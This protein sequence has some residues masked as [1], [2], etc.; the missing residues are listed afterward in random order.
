M[1]ENETEPGE[2]QVEKDE[3]LYRT[4]RTQF[5]MDKEQRL[6]RACSRTAEQRKRGYRETHLPADKTRELTEED[7]DGRDEA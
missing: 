3:D 7:L 6:V 1:K 5:W 4:D 2:R